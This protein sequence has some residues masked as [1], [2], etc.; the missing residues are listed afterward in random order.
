MI[1]DIRRSVLAKWC[2]PVFSPPG[3]Q[4]TAADCNEFMSCAGRGAAINPGHHGT[5]HDSTA[6]TNL[7]TTALLRLQ[8]AHIQHCHRQQQQLLSGEVI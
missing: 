3:P 1:C 6:L 7:Q 8:R 4:L 2:C 5:I